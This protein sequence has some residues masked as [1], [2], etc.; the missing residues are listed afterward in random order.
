[1]FMRWLVIGV[2]VMAACGERK[3]L[4]HLD[5][6]R[7]IEL[8]EKDA[9]IVGRGGEGLPS[10][11]SER[12]CAIEIEGVTDDVWVDCGRHV[13]LAEDA[14]GDRVAWRVTGEPWREVRVGT[15][16]RAW[17]GCPPPYASSDE[18]TFG[19]LPPLVT[20]APDLLRCAEAGASSVLREL[21]DEMH[22]RTGDAG[23]VAIMIALGRG[24]AIAHDTDPW[25]AIEASLAPPVRAQI[26]RAACG[27]TLDARAPDQA[28]ARLTQ[29]CPLGDPRLTAAARDRLGARLV[30]PQPPDDRLTAWL[31]ALALRGDV[32]ALADRACAAI[33]RGGASD[34]TIRAA[35]LVLLH[36]R[37]PCPA[38]DDVFAQAGAC[39]RSIWCSDAL[40]DGAPLADELR[41]AFA[42]LDDAPPRD[43]DVYLPLADSLL[44]AAA[45]AHGGPP[46]SFVTRTARAAY[47][48]APGR[49]RACD[50]DGVKPGAPCRCA[51][52]DVGARDRCGL[53]VDGTWM[54]VGDCMLRAD[55]HGK[56]I[57]GARK[58]RS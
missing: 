13:D 22:A 24:G 3:S 30:A 15:G 26:E 27:A 43:P 51:D 42:K 9:V 52:D 11:H 5:G 48:Y 56:K 55:D 45:R 44:L 6:T 1:M 23:V 25:A 57:V 32:A 47:T 41:T 19:P 33:G 14:D 12:G 54:Q 39:D 8:V 29:I 53:P 40:C 4:D 21:V 38:L 50:D 7:K 37:G 35:A 49:G 36:T 34:E 46:A 58:P 28:F 17:L 2:V 31:A 10:F 20:A 16:G 18:A